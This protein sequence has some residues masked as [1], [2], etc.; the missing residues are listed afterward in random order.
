MG[1]RDRQ[2]RAFVLTLDLTLKSKLGDIAKLEKAVTVIKLSLGKNSE[3]PATRVVGHKSKTRPRTRMQG[4]IKSSIELFIQPVQKGQV[5]TR[6]DL[7]LKS[8]H[9]KEIK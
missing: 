4:F 9:E 1:A 6:S 2:A 7:T 8:K 3:L 5:I